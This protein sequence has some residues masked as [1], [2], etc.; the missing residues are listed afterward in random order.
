[1]V[2]DGK[3]PV[4]SMGC[5]TPAAP[6]SSR[7]QNL[8][9]Y[10]RQHFAQVTNPPIDPLRESLVMSLDSYIGD[11][12]TDFFHFSPE[13][14]KMVELKRPVLSNRE[15]DILC[16]LRYKGFV[17]RKLPMS[18]DTS[19]GAEGMRRAIDSLCHQ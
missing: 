16:N 18:F 10:F 12:G 14:C 1:M 17:T 5:D 19:A 13:M 11:I 15:L 2:A 7:P 8:F 4:N 6:F 3:E 9:S